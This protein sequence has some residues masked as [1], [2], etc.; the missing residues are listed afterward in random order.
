[1]LKYMW[2]LLIPFLCIH[3]SMALAQKYSIILPTYNEKDN[4]PYVIYMIIKELKK[5]DIDFEIILVDDNSEDKTA[6][7]YRKLQSIFTEEKLLLIERKKKLGLG[8]AYMDALKIVSGNFVIIMDSDLSHHPKYIYDFI[9][10]QKETN[11]DIVTGTRYN[12]QG[13]ISGWTFKRVI[14]SRVANFLSQFL[15]FTNLTDLTGSFRLYRTD[16]LREVIQFVQGHGY[17]FQ[18]EVIIRANKLGKKIEEVGYVFVDRMFG[19]SKLS[20]NEIFQYLFGLLRLFWT[21]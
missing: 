13:G 18:M 16:V 8:S 9:K 17:V 15:L 14:I 11:C 7:V 19:Q 21:V 10:K 1:M 5:K 6:D 12:K 20:S 2:L 3:I 4:L